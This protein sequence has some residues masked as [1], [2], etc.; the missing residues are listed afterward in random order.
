ML[1]LSA[2]LAVQCTTHMGGEKMESNHQYNKFII[3][4][5]L[6]ILVFFV[7]DKSLAEMHTAVFGTWGAGKNQMFKAA[8]ENGFEIV[9]SSDVLKTERMGLKC[10]YPFELTKEIATNDMKWQVFVDRVKKIVTANKN[11]ATVFGWYLADE[12]DWN[13]IPPERY[14]ELNDIIKSI[15]DSKPTLVVLTIPN[16]WYKYLPYFDIIA[17]DPYLLN[18]Y[19]G[20]ETDKVQDW[21]D[22]VNSDF[23]KYKIDKPLWVVLGAFEQ[24]SKSNEKPAFRKP[25]PQEFD[26]MLQICLTNK[27]SGV[28][29]FSLFKAENPKN[30]GWNLLNDDPLLWETVRKTPKK[31]ISIK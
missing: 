26:V 13:D 10:L 12:P 6:L 18:T 7:A 11:Y 31:V 25:T 20:R 2:I 1:L 3:T 9:I 29:I 23:T 27:V 22:K 8:K 24:R 17:I 4:L 30:Y 19:T 28:I 15:D 21:I 14:K 16:K 5:L